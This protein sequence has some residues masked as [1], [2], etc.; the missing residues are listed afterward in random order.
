MA[1]KHLLILFIQFGALYFHLD[2]NLKKLVKFKSTNDTRNANNDEL[3]AYVPLNKLRKA[4]ILKLQLTPQLANNKYNVFVRAERK[5]DVF[6]GEQLNGMFNNNKMRCCGD[7]NTCLI[8]V[9]TLRAS[10][11]TELWLTLN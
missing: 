2:I 8:T 6:L 1:N 5:A 4:T 7:K 11:Q 10:F 3:D 9:S